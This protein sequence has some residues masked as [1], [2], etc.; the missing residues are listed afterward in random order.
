[1]FCV[2]QIRT[3]QLLLQNLP[4]LLDRVWH[5]SPK[6]IDKHQHDHTWLHSVIVTVHSVGR[7]V[8]HILLSEPFGWSTLL[9]HCAI[10]DNA[11]IRCYLHNTE[12]SGDSPSS[13]VWI[14]WEFLTQRLL[15]VVSLLHHTLSG[16]VFLVFRLQIITWSYLLC[17][18]N[19]GKK[20]IYTNLD[21]LL[22]KEGSVDERKQAGESRGRFEFTWM[23]VS[24][25]Q[26]G[27]LSE[28]EFK[29][30]TCSLT[31]HISRKAVPLH[32]CSWNKQHQSCGQLNV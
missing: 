25:S 21:N 9:Q 18:Q 14:P 29:Q 30:E 19:Q 20:W 16:H 4:C 7:N 28:P 32:Q 1:M 3:H 17:I 10:S 12:K 27:M 6:D 5:L 23:T 11:I 13:I 22:L 2:I 26:E 24:Y 8:M 15:S 31:L